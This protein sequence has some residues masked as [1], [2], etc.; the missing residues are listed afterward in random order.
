MRTKV[1]VSLLL[2]FSIAFLLIACNEFGAG[3]ATQII[4]PNDLL[5]TWEANYA[6][7]DVLDF[8]TFGF[9]SGI[10]RLSLMSDGFYRQ[11]FDNELVAQGTWELDSNH[12]LHLYGAKIFIY[13]KKWASEFS[14]DNVRAF[15]FDCE[16]D[17][18]ELDGSEL[19]LCV[20]KMS[21]GDIVLRHLE[22]GDP[23]SPVYITFERVR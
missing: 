13:G 19:I 3:T 1:S 23:D 17:K 20:K 15:T 14:Q 4:N 21:S 2:F 12:M 18:I 16:G 5:G 9:V 7:Y 10:E 11:Y 8:D 22:I 6:S